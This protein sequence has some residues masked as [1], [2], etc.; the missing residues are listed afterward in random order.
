MSLER[1]DAV[2]ILLDCMEG[3]AA[4]V[5]PD[6]QARARFLAP[7]VD[8]V[9]LAAAN[10]I[11]VLRVEVEFRDGHVEVAPTNR[12]FTGVKT[13][14]RLLAGSSQTMPMSELAALVSHGVRVVKR[15]IGAFAGSDLEWVLRGLGRSH[16][17]LA[18]L[19]TRGAILSTACQA[20]DLDYRVT[21]VGD[22]CFDPD[23]DVHRVLLGSVLPIR[24]AVMSVAEVAAALPPES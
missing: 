5:F 13:A 11:P 12:Y 6:P 1:A 2:V 23:P 22:A 15:R 7:V 21:V 18:G 24:A 20:A 9:R 8:L 3:T 14:G 19:V 4:S 16:L 17:L 10:G